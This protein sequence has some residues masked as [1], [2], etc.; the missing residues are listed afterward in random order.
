MRNPLFALAAFALCTSSACPADEGMWLLTHPPREAMKAAYGFEPTQQWLD[1]M[2]LSAVRFENGGSGSIVSGDGLVMTNHHVGSD[3]IA[4]LSTRERDL[5]NNGYYAKSRDQ[6]LKC[7][8]L[9]I[10]VLEE[11]IDVTQRVLAAGSGADAAEAATQRRRV[12]ADIEAETGSTAGRTREV[13]TLYQGGMYQL[14]VYKSYKDVRLVF[15]PEQSI[16]FFGGDT[17]NFEFPR[18]NLDCCFFRLYENDQPV[19]T[20]NHLAWSKEG[21]KDGEFIC[22][23]GHPGST[24]RALT[25]ANLA[26]VRD[27]SHPTRLAFVWRSEA[28]VAEFA[29]RSAENARLA[30]EDA[31]SWA[32][33]RKAFTGELAGLQ[34]GATFG[35]KVEAERKLRA[36]VDADPAL[37]ARTSGAWET[38]AAAQ[39]A[40]KKLFPR[41][42]ALERIARSGV[43]SQAALHIVRLADELPK[44]N[45]ERLPEYNESALPATYLSLYSPEP[46]ETEL[47]VVRLGNTLGYFAERFG[48]DD[49][50]VTKLLAGR[51]PMDRARDL[52]TGATFADPARRRALVEGG[53]AALAASADPMLEMARGLDAALRRLQRAFENEVEA[54]EQEGYAK[55]AAARFALNG[56]SEYPDAT[57]SLRMTYGSVRGLDDRGVAV[58]AFTTIGGLF[59][60]YAERKG[61]PGFELPP[62]WESAAQTLRKDLPFNFACTAD[63]IGGNSGSPVVN[64]AGELV[65]LIFDGNIHSL[66][67]AFVYDASKN[68]ALAVDAR[69]MIEALRTVYHADAMVAELT[70]SG[71]K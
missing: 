9:E 27:I 33:S 24:R 13:V 68:R 47:E 49:P 18:F 66:T 16:A 57:F 65:G 3:M 58:P 46:V 23:F 38:I 54:A 7:P 1:R 70:G 69:A 28:K 4:K 55:V 32:N 51:S 5:M 44:P 41:K 26:F 63:V 34:D 37:N 19:S 48:C 6:E 67:G 53:P 31:F 60:R 30:R 43:L 29:G 52:V 61:Q 10:R 42:Y 21:V 15:A 59:D 50:I 11:I 62:S 39:E 17:D 45:N 14:H 12:I 22:V 20:P 8:D 36:A 35:A 71:Q 64:R 25:A 2:R 40:N 56:A